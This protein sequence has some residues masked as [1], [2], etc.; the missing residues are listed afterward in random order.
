MIDCHAHLTSEDFDRDLETVLQRAAAAGV[1]GII[2]VGEDNTD[3]QRVLELCA[4]HPEQ[5]KA[6]IGFH[7]DRFADG[8]TP[9]ATAQIDRFFDMVRQHRPQLA[10]IGEVGLDFWTTRDHDRRAQQ[11]LFLE[12]LA[13]LALELDLP[14]NIHSRSA[15]RYALDLLAEIGVRRV[16]MHAF[17]GKAGHA[18]R[19]A[20]TH[21]WLF[22]IPPSVVRSVQKQKLA[23]LLPLEFMALESDSPVLGPDR[24]QRN[25]P[26]NLIHTV[27]LIAAAKSISAEAVCEITTR[28]AQRLFSVFEKTPL[29]P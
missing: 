26:A 23:R 7:P 20:E 27:Q 2:V 10:G 24:Q 28:N 22:S 5:L 11:R 17:D 14:L 15:G 1:E 29:T 6:C 12:R 25:E 19:A 21:G 13:L 18:M 16:L 4:A 9:P 3:N 8:K